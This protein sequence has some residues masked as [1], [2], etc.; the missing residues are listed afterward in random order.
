[1]GKGSTQFS[2]SRTAKARIGQ[3][4]IIGLAKEFEE[5]YRPGRPLPLRY[6]KILARSGCFSESGMKR[7][8]LRTATINFY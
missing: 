5:I 2:L 1:M 7:T 4:S 6:R 8:V 3:R